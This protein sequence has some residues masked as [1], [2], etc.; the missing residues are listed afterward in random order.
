VFRGFYFLLAGTER[1]DPDRVAFHRASRSGARSPLTPI[2]VLLDDSSLG[3]SSS[4]QQPSPEARVGAETTRPLPCLPPCATS[5]A[6]SGCAIHHRPRCRRTYH[7]IC[8][9]AVYGSLSILPRGV[10]M[11]CAVW[12][13]I[14]LGEQR[15]TLRSVQHRL[16]V[17]E[18]RGVVGIFKSQ[19]EVKGV[20][21]R[22]GSRS[23]LS[24]PENLHSVRSQ[25]TLGDS[26]EC[27]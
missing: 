20:R 9:V 4:Q 27:N 24:R 19:V 1:C 5:C 25:R 12:R 6:Q 15:S 23:D 13:S 22:G 11:F 2:P 17:S 10:E 3:P 18:W 8:S 16:P 7:R 14:H 21:G 26:N